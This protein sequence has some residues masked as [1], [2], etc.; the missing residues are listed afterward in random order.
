M[1]ELVLIKAANNTLLPADAQSAALLDR[2]KRGAGVLVRYEEANDIALHRKMMVLF[3]LA[4]DAWQP[5]GPRYLGYVIEKEFNQLR[6]DLV[7]LAGY[8]ERYTDP[9]GNTRL[10]A[11]SLAFDSME[12]PTREALFSAL[13]DVVLKHILPTYNKADLDNVIAQ[14]LGLAR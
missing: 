5:T 7:I 1:P 8:Y 11:Q 4:F 13:I 9:D 3:N 14:T 12:A 6:K 10:N 2:I